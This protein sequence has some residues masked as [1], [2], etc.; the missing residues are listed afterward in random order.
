MTYTSNLE[1]DEDDLTQPGPLHST[2][3]QSKDSLNL[4]EEID[5]GIQTV[6]QELPSLPNPIR[7]T[8]SEEQN[9]AH[10]ITNSSINTPEPKRP[11]TNILVKSLNQ[12]LQQNQGANNNPFKSP[13]ENCPVIPF[14]DVPG[15]L[16]VADPTTKEII[17][18]DFEIKN[19]TGTG[20]FTGIIYVM[21][22]KVLPGSEKWV[23]PLGMYLQKS[24]T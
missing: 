24:V 17:Y 16:Q 14:D 2:P 8:E 7:E 9:N 4:T 18:F 6:I 12:Y 10:E 3:A 22:A 23:Q 13:P 19:S 5:K 15:A 20:K 21:N 1:S 11:K